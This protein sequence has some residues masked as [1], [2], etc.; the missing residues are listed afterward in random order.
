MNK[1]TNLDRE[2]SE[3]KTTSDERIPSDYPVRPGQSSCRSYLHSGLCVRGSNCLF[4]HPRCKVHIRL[5]LMDPCSKSNTI[6]IWVFTCS[7]FWED[8][9]R[10]AQLVNFFTQRTTKL[11]CVKCEKLSPKGQ[12]WWRTYAS[13]NFIIAWLLFLFIQKWKIHK[14]TTGKR[15][16]KLKIGCSI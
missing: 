8:F 15:R 2:R 14:V 6:F 10:T 3:P 5:K 11:L 12:G 16:R 1:A 13:G 9:V 7:S 4:N